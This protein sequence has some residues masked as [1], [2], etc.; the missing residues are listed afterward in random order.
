EQVLEKLEPFLPFKRGVWTAAAPLPGGD[1]KVDA[2][3]AE[4]A[5][6]ETD[7]PFLDT[8]FATR[9]IRHYGTDARNL[10]GDAQKLSDLG[11]QFGHTLFEREVRWLMKREWAQTAEDVLWRRT[12]LGLRLSR[13]D[14]GELD[15]FMAGCL[16]GQAGAAA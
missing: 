6:L 2:V 5:R 13:E 10:L 9:L 14:A 7:Y 4:V 8:A 11:R 16:A 15:T 1:F 3:D 12:K